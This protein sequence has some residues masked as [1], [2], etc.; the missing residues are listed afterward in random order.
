MS[1]SLLDIYILCIYLVATVRATYKYFSWVQASHRLLLPSPLPSPPHP[2]LFIEM[3]LQCVRVNGSIVLLV[4]YN[5]SM[6]DVM[7]QGSTKRSLTEE[8]LSTMLVN[9]ILKCSL[10]V[11]QYNIPKAIDKI[12]MNYSIKIKY[13]SM[14]KLLKSW[15]MTVSVISLVALNI[16]VDFPSNK[17]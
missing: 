5:L 12:L 8:T 11:C 4:K 1:Q 17:D 7:T 13:S 14:K 16:P 10:F 9:F 2:N 3:F 15:I 6:I